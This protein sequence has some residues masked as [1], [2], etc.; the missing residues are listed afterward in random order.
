MIGRKEMCIV[1]GDNCVLSVVRIPEGGFIMGR[2]TC[3]P[4]SSSYPPHIVELKEFWIGKYPITQEQWVTVCGS[5]SSLVIGGCKP[6]NGVTWYDS[7]EF[8]KKLSRVS[9]KY[10]FRLLSEAEWEYA[11]RAGSHTEFPLGSNPADIDQYAWYY[12]NSEGIIHPVGQLKPNSWG[13]YDMLGNVLEW[14]QD[15]WYGGYGGAPEDGSARLDRGQDHFVT[16]GGYYGSC[17]GHIGN[18]YRR[19]SYGHSDSGVFSFRVALS[20]KMREN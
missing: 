15:V 11:C 20:L 3:N 10:D 13:V 14:C 9:G 2:G 5:N 8:C 12:N 18:S 19:K 16:R 6:V 4:R 7:V 1:I 17:R